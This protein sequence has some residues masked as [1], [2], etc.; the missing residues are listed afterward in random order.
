MYYSIYNNI[1]DMYITL[2]SRYTKMNNRENRVV[3][4]FVRDNTIIF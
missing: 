4:S 1:R 2:I 3:T